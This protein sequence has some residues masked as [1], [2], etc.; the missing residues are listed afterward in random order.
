VRTDGQRHGLTLLEILAAVSILVI[1]AVPLIQAMRTGS[2][3]VRLGRDVACAMLLAESVLEVVRARVSLL[4]A[5]AAAGTTG[6][7]Q[8]QQRFRDLAEPGKKKVVS[9]NASEVS[10]FFKSVVAPATGSGPATATPITAASDPVTFQ[11]LSGFEVETEVKFEVNGAIIDSDGD[12]RAE[13][14]MCEFIVTVHW[15]EPKLGDRSYRLS[16]LFS[17]RS[18]VPGGA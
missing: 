15:K 17:M 1:A 2:S 11:A 18:I 14:D 5:P 12:H 9:A 8:W 10:S 3:S 6:L 4:E 7:S 16:A 13:P